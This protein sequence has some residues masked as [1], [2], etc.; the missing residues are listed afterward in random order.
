MQPQ[1]ASSGRSSVASNANILLHA[2]HAV[3]CIH[4]HSNNCDEGD[5]ERY[6]VDD[7]VDDGDGD[8]DG[9]NYNDDDD[10]GRCR[11]MPPP[12]HSSVPARPAHRESSVQVTRGGGGGGEMVKGKRRRRKRGGGGNSLRSRWR[13]K[14]PG[15]SKPT[16][17]FQFSFIQSHASAALF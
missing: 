17:P 10:E 4:H 15:R 11:W 2:T 7:C 14:P 12:L 9:N 3:P 16:P 8:D 1:F 13:D 6:E 5:N